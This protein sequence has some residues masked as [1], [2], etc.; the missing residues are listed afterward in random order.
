MSISYDKCLFR[1][2]SVYFVQWSKRNNFLPLQWSNVDKITYTGKKCFY[3]LLHIQNK[4][5]IIKGGQI[6]QGFGNYYRPRYQFQI[7]CSINST[8]IYIRNSKNFKNSRALEI[9]NYALV[10]I[11]SNWEFG[12]LI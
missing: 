2:V 5:G 6:G 11:H 9:L 8:K 10:Q 1:T 4:E 12:M 3:Y 7:T